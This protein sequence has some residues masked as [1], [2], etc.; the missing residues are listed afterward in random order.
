MSETTNALTEQHIETVARWLLESEHPVAFTGAGISTDSGIPDFRGP[1]GVWTKNPGAERRASIHNYLADPEVRRRS[2]QDR[3]TSPAL[4]A[5]PNAGSSGIR[6]GEAAPPVIVHF[7]STKP[8]DIVSSKLTKTNVYDNQNEKIGEIEDLVIQDG[9]TITGVVVSA[10]GFLG[11]GEHYV[12]IDPAS[13]VIGKK[14]H[15]HEGRSLI[16][17]KTT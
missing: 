8:A 3:L 10:G 17:A 2:W 11:M 14:R 1:Q 16:P 7:V 12:L 4:S 9:K 13:I 15:L 6:I 5:Q